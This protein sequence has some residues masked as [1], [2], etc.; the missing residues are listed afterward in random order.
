M[1]FPSLVRHSESF[2][3]YL[4]KIF[5]ILQDRNCQYQ[6]SVYSIL[7]SHKAALSWDGFLG[8]YYS[9]IQPPH[10]V[11]KDRYRALNLLIKANFSSVIRY[12]FYHRRILWVG[13][14]REEPH[15]LF[16]V[17]LEIFLQNMMLLVI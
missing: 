14:T 1:L 12:Y 3:I 16:C 11:V 10:L 4:L 17:V 15:P 13:Y 2:L 6:L 5:A 7:N 8:F 9:P